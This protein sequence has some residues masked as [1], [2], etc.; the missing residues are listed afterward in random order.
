MY[1]KKDQAIAMA[2]VP[3]KPPRVRCP[4][5]GGWAL[6]NEMPSYRGTLTAGCALA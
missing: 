5:S 1:R 2:G 6:S 4:S 3:L